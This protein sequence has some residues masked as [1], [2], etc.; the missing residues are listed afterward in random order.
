MAVILILDDDDKL[1]SL[2]HKYL[3]DQH[4]LCFTA[5]NTEQAKKI[6]LNEKIDL[7]ILDVMMP[8]ESGINF[9]SFLKSHNLYNNIAILMLSALGDASS[10][11]NGLEVGADDYLGKPFEPKELLL[12]IQKL[13]TRTTYDHSNIVEFGELIF[14]LK[15]LKLH[16]SGQPIDLSSTEASLLK[17][18]ASKLNHPF[19]RE[20]LAQLNF[21]ISDRSVDVQIVRLRV[22]IEDDSKKPKYIITVRNQG[23]GLFI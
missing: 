14:N 21:G 17:I 4:F 9:A 15:S 6:L 23:Y 22:K 20:E 2:L 7:I 5:S 13:I 19:S 16:K 8:G 3:T 10:R 11:I 18:L 1:R 12:R